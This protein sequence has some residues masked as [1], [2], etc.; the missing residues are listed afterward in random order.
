MAGAD[1]CPGWHPRLLLLEEMRNTFLLSLIILSWFNVYSQVFCFEGNH[2]FQDGETATYDV[3]YEWGP[4]WIQAARVTFTAH[5]EQYGHHPCWHLK[6][7]GRTLRS[8]E[9][10]YKVRDY[11]ESWVDTVT[12]R[13]FEFIRNIYESGYTLLNTQYWDQN[14]TRVISN[15]KVR[16]QPVRSDTLNPGPCVFDMLSSIYYTRTLD[17]ASFP[18]KE[19]VSVRVIIDE[20]AYDIMIRHLGK[21]MVINRDKRTYKCNKFGVKMVAGTIFKEG[22]E[23]MVWITDDAQKIPVYIEAKI[24]VGSVKAYLRNVTIDKSTVMTDMQE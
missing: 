14:S 24:I 7:A 12:F 16:Q 3:T 21:E 1:H 17:L 15:T 10:L 11:Y 18:L 5:K 13:T 9:F 6:V 22:E 23:V 20:Q 4:L 2:A 19:E 8:F